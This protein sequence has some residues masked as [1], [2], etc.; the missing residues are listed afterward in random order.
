MRLRVYVPE[1]SSNCKPAGHLGSCP[2]HACP[3]PCRQTN[4]PPTPTFTPTP[5]FLLPNLPTPPPP[6][7]HPGRR[8]G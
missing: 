2:L 5:T 4:D 7:P 6:R 3:P 8:L 1:C